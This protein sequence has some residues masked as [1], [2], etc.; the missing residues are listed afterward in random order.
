MQM[1]I[2][3]RAQ[4][5]KHPGQRGTR[6]PIPLQKRNQS[7]MPRLFCPLPP[8][9]SSFSLDFSSLVSHSPNYFSSTQRNFLLPFSLLALSLHQTD[10]RSLSKSLSN[11]SLWFFTI[12]PHLSC[13]NFF[14]FPRLPFNSHLLSWVSHL[15]V[16]L[17]LP[18]LPVSGMSLSLLSPCLSLPNFSGNLSLDCSSLP[19]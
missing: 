9:L 5:C 13:P 14:L 12:I 18:L 6:S 17:I 16:S 1:S 7:N 19:P 8:S 3:D 11:H 4:L 15:S 10:I 2:E